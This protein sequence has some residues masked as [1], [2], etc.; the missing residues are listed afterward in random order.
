M[1][2]AVGR[3]LAM[4]LLAILLSGCALQSDAPECNTDSVSEMMVKARDEWG[5]AAG[6]DSGYEAH[7]KEGG[8]R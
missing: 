6:G 7:C 1:V 3:L 2:M 4:M 8:Q 5:G